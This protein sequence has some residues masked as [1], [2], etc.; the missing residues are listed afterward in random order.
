MN[1]VLQ[2]FVN[3]RLNLAAPDAFSKVVKKTNHIGP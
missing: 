3:V 1:Q 2:Y